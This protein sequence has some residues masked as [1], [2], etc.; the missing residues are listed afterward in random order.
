MFSDRHAR[1]EKECEW[2]GNRFMARVERVNAGKGRFCSLVCAN[3]WQKQEG[4]KTWGFENGRKYWNGDSWSVQWQDENGM[5]NTS[6]AKWWW[7]LNVG[8]VPEGYVII[9]KDGNK[10]NISSNNF[11]LKSRAEINRE[12]GTNSNTVS[13]GFKGKKHSKESKLKMSVARTGK[14][15]S[16]IHKQNIGKSTKKS[17]KKGIFDNVKFVD[18]R[19]EK[20]PGWRGGVGQEYPDEFNKE[21]K[22]IIR[23]RDSNMCQIC[24]D[25]TGKGYK[26]GHIHHIDGHKENCDYDNLVLLCQTCHTKVHK[27]KDQSSPV[28]MSFR[29]KL[30][31]NQ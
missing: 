14:I 15:L 8:D 12:N 13:F 22:N 10:E 20:N 2:C 3:A 7:I 29:S 28:I 4:Q 25:R 6:Y 1:I 24:G 18:W 9:Y 27:S 23:E 30:Y 17:W 19:K 31:W 16:D 26:I 11:D 5:H 21:L